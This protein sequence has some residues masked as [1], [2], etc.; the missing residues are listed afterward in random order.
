MA[1]KVFD[2]FSFTIVSLVKSVIWNCIRY[3]EVPQSHLDVVSML[4]DRDKADP[5]TKIFS[6]QCGGHPQ[7]AGVKPL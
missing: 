7:P 6:H 5:Q 1:F 4:L 2:K 3:P